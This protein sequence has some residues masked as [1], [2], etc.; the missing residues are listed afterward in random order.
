ML[1]LQVLTEALDGH[2]SDEGATEDTEVV[3]EL[4]GQALQ[5]VTTD[6]DEDEEMLTI[7]LRKRKS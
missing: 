1:R 4:G 5:F 3:F 7:H 6:F 2:I